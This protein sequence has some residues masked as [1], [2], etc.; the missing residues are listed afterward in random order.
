MG[1]W[2]AQICM[3]TYIYICMYMYI[4]TCIYVCGSYGVL[5]KVRLGLV[6]NVL[7]MTQKTHWPTSGIPE[8]KSFGTFQANSEHTPNLPSRRG[9]HQLMGACGLVGRARALCIMIWVAAVLVAKARISAQC[10]QSGICNIDMTSL[11]KAILPRNAPGFLGSGRPVWLLESPAWRL[12][13]CSANC[14]SGV[15]G[16]R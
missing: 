14:T 11:C 7:T 1:G 10:R 15:Y 16:L 13:Q 6:S 12:H 5:L 3:C 2:V 9:P 4:Y 8:K